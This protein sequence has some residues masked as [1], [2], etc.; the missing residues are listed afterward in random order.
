M[1]KI[2]R[3]FL[4]T[5]MVCVVFMFETQSVLAQP[6]VDEQVEE[7]MDEA[8]DLDLL[9][10]HMDNGC[11]ES[12]ECGDDAEFVFSDG[13]LEISG[14]GKI[15]G[16]AFARYHNIEQVTIN[17]GITI[18]GE[19]AFCECEGLRS[20]T[21]PSS[22]TTIEEYAFEYCENLK[23]VDIPNGVEVIGFNAFNKCILLESIS[24]P[25][26]VTKIDA[27]AFCRCEALK[28][29]RFNSGDTSLYNNV[30]FSCSN[31]TII[32]HKGG[33]VEQYAKDNNINFKDID[34]PTG[35]IISNGNIYIIIATTLV[36]AGIALALIVV[37][38][39]NYIR[40]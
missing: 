13:K 25:A 39:R 8:V 1:K 3:L 16:Y 29:V 7:P 37:K 35:S 40:N 4:V 20:V 28:N 5:L 27:Y 10:E 32:S 19:E 6:V 31:L 23:K 12:G 2:V 34:N 30:F 26:S 18:I 15:N 33:A 24:I 36:I 11:P 14:S 17:E 21:M 38:K 9:D 22:L